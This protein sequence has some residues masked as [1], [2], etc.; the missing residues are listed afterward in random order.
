MSVLTFPTRKGKGKRA[1]DIA[2]IY[3]DPTRLA[4]S[5]ELKAA[6]SILHKERMRDDPAYRKAHKLAGAIAQRRSYLAHKTQK[7]NAA[8]AR[9]RRLRADPR[10]RAEYMRKTSETHYRRRIEKLYG[11]SL[12]QYAVLLEKQGNACAICRRRFTKEKRRAACVDHDHE[13]GRVRGLLCTAC[14]F[15]LGQAKRQPLLA[16]RCCRLSPRREP[17]EKRAA[18]EETGPPRSADAR[19]ADAPPARRARLAREAAVKSHLRV[20]EKAAKAGAPAVGWQ[21]AA[22]VVTEVDF[23]APPFKDATTL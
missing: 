7:N 3:A 16:L 11:L 19:K 22:A 6:W 15:A 13:T 18:P 4:R 5:R 9:R 23:V 1:A 17:R 20:H 12:E 8:L 2:R 14:N 21:T 10:T